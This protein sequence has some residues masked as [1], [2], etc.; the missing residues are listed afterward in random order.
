MYDYMNYTNKI[1]HFVNVPHTVS[2]LI[3][4]KRSSFLK[5]VI[6]MYLC[7]VNAKTLILS[8]E[9]SFG[10]KILRDDYALNICDM[11]LFKIF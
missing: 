2:M 6:S 11:I 10:A 9:K 8:Y 5:G 7:F 4:I 3:M 1:C